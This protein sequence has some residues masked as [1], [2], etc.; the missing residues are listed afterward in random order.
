M[1]TYVGFSTIGVNQPQ[2]SVRA[3]VFGGVGNLQYQPLA[4]KK[5]VITDA[6][7]VLRD[8][9]NALSIQ[10][11]SKVGQPDYGTTLWTY[12]FEPSDEFTLQAIE[13]EIRRVINQ[14]SR[15]YLN[16]LAVYSQ[17]N[18]VLVQVE[19]SFNPFNNPVNASFF[20]NRYDGSIQQL[21]Q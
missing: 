13:D 16:S 14:D 8:L 11:G 18:G 10:Q 3:G 6:N 2:D 4:G 1:A 7:L 15:I 5:F 21:A 20:L 9:L 12:V 19:M 17:D